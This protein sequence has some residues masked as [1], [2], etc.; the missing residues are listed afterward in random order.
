MEELNNYYYDEQDNQKNSPSNVT[1]LA[2]H[3]TKEQRRDFSDVQKQIIYRRRRMSVVGILSVLMLGFL[4]T[5][6]IKNLTHISVL[7]KEYASSVKEQASLTDKQDLLSQEVE[8]LND[9]EYLAKLARQKLLIS[10]E[11]E[12]VYYIPKLDKKLQEDNKNNQ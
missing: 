8:L 7:E 2:T 3:Y 10:A 11:D 6:I 12:T 5:T 4:G 9:P 1:E